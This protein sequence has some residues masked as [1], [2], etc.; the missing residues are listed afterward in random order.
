MRAL[1]KGRTRH[2]RFPMM[3]EEIVVTRGPRTMQIETLED[4]AE[5]PNG[6]GLL[7]VSWDG[8]LPGR[9]RRKAPYVHEWENPEDLDEQLAEWTEDGRRL[10]L[11]VTDTNINHEVFIRTYE[12]SRAGGHGDVTYSIEFVEWK[13]IEVRKQ[14]RKD[15]KKK[16]RK[17]RQS[18]DETG[19]RGNKDKDGGGKKRATST[20]YTVKAGDTLW[21]IAK[22][23]LGNGN[24]W[25]EIYE[26]PENRKAIGSNPDV[27]KVGTKLRI[28]ED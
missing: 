1:L 17:P 23:F 15:K 9:A 5:I 20:H 10:R 28:P 8:M 21:T 12:A 13:D 27:L 11:I 22:K 26:I 6:P 25:R 16:D 3:P 19:R 18:D 24:R 7:R 14:P 4:S 2:I